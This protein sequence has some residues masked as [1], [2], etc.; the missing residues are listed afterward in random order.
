M[1]KAEATLILKVKNLGKSAVNNFTK[2]LKSVVFTAG[3]VVNALKSIARAIPEFAKLA[4]EANSVEKAFTNLAASQGKDS[5]EMLNNMKD[6]S[7]GTIS[8]LELMKQANNALLLGLPVDKFGDMLK[9]ARS[10]SKATGQSMEF[11]LQSIVL[12]LGRGSKLILDNLGIIVKTEDAYK[13][14]AAASGLLAEKLTDAQKKQAFIN[15]AMRIGKANADKM[16]GGALTLTDRMAALGAKFKNAEVSLSRDLNPSM[17][18]LVSTIDTLLSQLQGLNSKTAM[19]EFFTATSLAMADLSSGLVLTLSNMGTR[20]ASAFRGFKL[21]ATL[22]FKEFAANKKATDD[23][24][25]KREKEAY[26]AQLARENQAIED[27]RQLQD[28]KNGNFKANLDKKSEIQKEANEKEKFDQAEFFKVKSEEELLREF[29][30]QQLLSDQKLQGQIKT[31]NDQIKNEK[32]YTARLKALRDKQELIEK[33]SEAI[34]TSELTKM[35]KFKEFIN[36]EEIKGKE[37]TFN[38]ISSLASSN[39]KVLA[40]IGKAAAI[41]SIVVNTARGVGQALGAFPPPFSFAMAGLVGVAGAAQVAKVSGVQL[42]EGGIVS[43]RPGGIQAT[44][45]E[46]GRDEAVIPLPKGF[47]ANQGL[48]GNS[49]TIVVNGGLLGDESSAREL[50]VALDSEL[51]KLRQDNESLSFDEGIT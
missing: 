10:A 42:A 4:S 50:A 23:I 37:Q 31:F 8:D 36:S 41:A 46:G 27:L 40:A 48:G 45:G 19:A 5:T 13:R 26:A 34:R 17:T 49:F 11:M 28:I 30:Q 16:G 21:L 33:K 35:Q 15:E 39:N 14:F 7:K 9:V 47:D 38:R 18:V 25:A 29:V 12:G 24:I 20:I 43:A 44:I 32:V 51:L 2:A 1:A 3:D 6:L 22:N